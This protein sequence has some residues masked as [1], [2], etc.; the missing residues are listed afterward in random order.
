MH[1]KQIFIL[2][3]YVTVFFNAAGQ[4]IKTSVV[5]FFNSHSTHSFLNADK[6]DGII[7]INYFEEDALS[8]GTNYQRILVPI[9]QHYA[10][11]NQDSMIQKAVI[12]FDSIPANSYERVRNIA[13]VKV[14]SVFIEIGHQNTSGNADTI[15]FHLVQADT[16]GF[17]LPQIYWSDTVITT[18]GFSSGNNW[19]NTFVYSM[20]INEQI[21]NNENFA[22]EINYFGHTNDSFGIVA[23]Y[24]FDGNCSPIQ[25][26][27]AVKS[28]FYPNSY[29]Y[30][31]QWHLLLPSATGGDL[32]YDCDSDEVYNDSIDGENFIQNWHIG[33]RISSPNISTTEY[34]DH[35][36][37]IFPNP[38][39]NWVTISNVQVGANLEIITMDGKLIQK[40]NVQESNP[41]IFLGNV[42]NGMYIIK[43]HYLDKIRY[44]KIVVAH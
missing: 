12:G 42:P 33:V 43:I 22:I 26:K 24:P 29:A 11:A 44:A 27:R 1:L 40:M 36:L 16:N 37:T 7:H 4:K 20:A 19:N 13:G 5:P 41:S 30:W 23:A 10:T 39:A 32:F 21:A 6:I 15:I 17:P 14:D 25:N 35:L 31:N 38:T 3:L 18:T 2:F 8:F 28:S 34:E 9:N